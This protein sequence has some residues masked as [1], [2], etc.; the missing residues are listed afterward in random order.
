MGGKRTFGSGRSIGNV[1]GGI[2]TLMAK[3]R[4]QEKPLQQ[5]SSP[6]AARLNVLDALR[7]FAL[8]GIL[9]I[10]LPH[11]GWLIDSGEPLPGVRSGGASTCLWW[12]QTLF[13]QGNMR[14]LFSLLFGASVLLFLAKAERESATRRQAHVL[15]LRRLFWLLVFGAINATL[16]LWPGDILNVYAMAGL[17]VLPFATSRPRTLCISAAVVIAATSVI[18]TYQQ[19]PKREI[20][21]QGPVLE[22]QASAGR[23]LAS[24]EQE[25]LERW[26]H[27]QTGKFAAPKEIA[28]ER[29]A[30]LGGYGANL[31]F[32]AAI[33]WD[34]FTDWLATARWVLD[35]VG[36][37]LVGMVLFRLG[38]L[39]AGAST[40]TYAIMIAVGY[41]VGLPLKL[42]EAFRDWHLFMG[43]GNPQFWQFWLPAL[44]M[45]PARLFV[46]LGHV[47][48][49]LW[50][51]KVFRLRLLPLQALGRMAFTGYL[52]QSV[53]GAI[54]FSGFG[55]ALWGSLNLPQLWL[56]AAAIWGIEIAFSLIWLSRFSMGPF[57]WIWRA[58]T[59]QRWPRSLRLSPAT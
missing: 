32:L 26:R 17:L 29:A 56:L 3:A 58:L 2:T 4:R 38:W 59:F 1:A 23:V 16:L 48:L 36:F 39:Q 11:M 41:G 37:M 50:C 27:W 10:N 52:M 46:T 13:V 8:C 14:G 19:L 45:Q 40:R 30:R 44:T 34:W 20:L 24:A 7:G 47:G 15:M 22:E 57:E 53:L 33:S 31:R 18:M 6:R 21:A 49:F 51:W 42:I 12:V 35:A 9:L 25:K 5:D 43:A 54:A 55:L 28:T